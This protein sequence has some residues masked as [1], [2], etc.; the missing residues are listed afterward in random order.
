MKKF[1]EHSKITVF[2]SPALLMYYQIINHV[3]FT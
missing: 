3:L 2:N 1:F